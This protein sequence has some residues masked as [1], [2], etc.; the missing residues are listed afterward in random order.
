MGRG[1]SGRYGTGRGI[2]GEVHDGSGDPWRGPGGV[3]G[4]SERSGRGRRT[5]EKV[6][7]GSSDPRG[8]PDRFVEP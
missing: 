2:L 6:R 1:P 5:L 7:D 8:G 4:P 3:V